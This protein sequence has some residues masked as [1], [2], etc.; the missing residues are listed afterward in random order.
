M[1]M[2]IQRAFW[3][4]LLSLW[5]A[6]T[7]LA[8]SAGT[9][10]PPGQN[11]LIEAEGTVEGMR[12]GVD[13]WFP[14]QTNLV[15]NIHDKVRTGL[16]SRAAVRLSN[17]SI[18]RLNK[19]TTIEIQPP[20]EATK[21]TIL[22]LKSGAAYFYNREQPGETTFRTPT[23]SGAIRGT[24]F[25]LTVDD[26]GTTVIS[27]IDGAVDLRN[28]QG[29]ITLVSGEQ[30]MAENGKPPHKTAVLEAMNLIQWALYYPGV[31][32][33]R[34]ISLSD[35]EQ[36]ALDTSLAAYKEGDLLRAVSEYPTNRVAGSV[37]EKVYHAAILLAVGQVEETQ[38]ILDGLAT[39]D[40]KITHLAESLSELIAAVRYKTFLRKSPPADPTD[41]LAHSYYEQ[42]RSRLESAREAAR[43]AL[44]LDPEFGFAWARLGEL[45]FSFGKNADALTAANK[46]LQFSTRNAE[47]HSLQGFLL[48][49]KEKND[50]ALA[51]FNRAIELDGALGNAWLG[52]GLIQIR[53]GHREAGRK[54]LQ[55]A[56]ALEP[57]RALLRSYLGKAQFHEGNQ[58]LAR[59]EL[60]L[61]RKM[62]PGDPTPFL[63]S[64]L[65][66]QQ[67]NKLNEAVRDL[68]KSQDLNDNRSVFRSRLLL[69]QDH[70]VRSANLASIY[71]DDGLY[72]QSIREAGRAV[73]YDYGNYSAHLFLAESYD[74][75][76]DPR[77]VN[78]RYETPWLSELF[79]ANL[80]APVQGGNL[81]QNIS[82]QEYSRLFEGDKLGFSSLTEYFSN[83]DWFQRASQYG[84][85]GDFGY[86]M[87]V[88][89]RSQNGWRL[90]NDLESTTGFFKAKEQ[91]TP[92][93]SILLQGIYYNYTSG[94]VAQYYNQQSASQTQRI[95]ERQE[96]LIFAGYHH[97]WDPGVHSLLLVGHFD[98]T[99]LREDHGGTNIQTII[100]NPNFFANN[101]RRSTLDYRSELDGYSAEFQQ[102]WDVTKHNIIAGTRFQTG[103]SDTFTR[104]APTNSGIF[105]PI[106]TTTQMVQTDLQRFNVYVYD[107]YQVFE[108]L[109]LIG[110]ISYDRLHYPVNIDIAPITDRESVRD[111]VSPKAG[112]ILRT[113]ENA[114]LRGAYTRSLGGVFF[115]NSL[116]LEPVQV[117]GFTQAYRSLIPES[118]L[119]I[120]PGARFETY[121]VGFDEKLFKNTYFG[122]DAELLT[123]TG[124][125]VQGAYA[126]AG[127]LAPGQIS[128]ITQALDY[129]EKSL[130][131]SLNQLIGKQWSLGA[132]YRL[133]SADLATRHGA[134]PL[135]RLDQDNEAALHQLNLYAIFNES[136]GFF[137]QFH[138]IWNQQSNQGYTPDIP[139]DDFWHLNFYAG[140][141]FYRRHAEVGLGVLNLTD[142][143][144]KL[145]PL[146]LYAE[147]PRER[148]FTA[149]LKLNF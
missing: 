114:F 149:S 79:M 126:F 134:F 118:V 15:L 9:N 113:W 85:F 27:M 146:T 78:L 28:D 21:R 128:E 86:A 17:Q 111:Q 45:E 12:Y 80:L 16:K 70:A 10:S 29:T 95:K 129:R 115:D 42:S 65:L 90:N 112:F 8:Q 66:E 57:N 127:P 33:L 131:V 102:V 35:A 54:D 133:T 25:Y 83:G 87:D 139:G 47:A 117:A 60:D 46:A 110:G 64:A 13:K 74:A 40:A 36:K 93:D 49:A 51:A 19:L 103:E 77:Q 143:D 144:Y 125:Q 50:Q 24:E 108:P 96:P 53:Q 68:E 7:V 88:D 84:N 55:T 138:A 22:D 137:S 48:A 141:R 97:E 147:L 106:P 123:S 23:A 31:L 142:R 63:Y 26:A 140:Y 94:D 122:I 99:F 69:D 82:Q 58:R 121:H 75:L 44:H 3:G 81:S 67:E 109:Q 61:A 2:C 119:G 41:W 100:P 89:Y 30:G 37:S 1:G 107:S 116:R 130:Y 98:D 52:R 72:D 5:A 145:N 71:R 132:R 39:D 135:S 105:F 43:Q 62:D 32:D 73:N 59:K 136:C 11:I 101:G 14:A 6:P 120:V 104:I 18:L 38:E 92:Q 20:E 4:L 34:D 76:R 56:A 148:T 91:I 124:D